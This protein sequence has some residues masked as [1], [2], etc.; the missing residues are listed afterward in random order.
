[1]SRAIF[2]R[3]VFLG[4][5]IAVWFYMDA[6]PTLDLN[7]IACARVH[8]KGSDPLPA[9]APLAAT[10]RFPETLTDGLCDPLQG[11]ILPAAPSAHTVDFEFP[12]V[13]L[14]E[15][16]VI[17]GAPTQRK[18]SLTVWLSHQ[19]GQFRAIHHEDTWGVYSD[20]AGPL[21][22]G[23]KLGPARSIHLVLGGAVPTELRDVA[24]Y[25]RA[26]RPFALFYSLSLNVFFPWLLGAAF[27]LSIL[28]WGALALILARAME[29]G[30]ISMT[31][32]RQWLIGA[33]VYTFLCLGWMWGGHTL[34]PTSAWLVVTVVVGTFELWRRW[35]QPK[36]ES[37]SD[38]D[39]NA[40]NDWWILAWTWRL[41]VWLLVVNMVDSY[42]ITHTR[43]GPVDHLLP[44]LGARFL[45]DGV[46][47]PA[48][49]AH[50]PWLLHLWF[51]PFVN[52]LRPWDYWAYL[53]FLANLNSLAL[54]IVP[55]WLRRWG[56][57]QRASLRRAVGCLTLM[58]LIVSFH[59]IGQRPFTALWALLAIWWWT[60]SYRFRDL[61]GGL[62]LT[63]AI[64]THPSA[65]FVL[66][67]VVF[68]NWWRAG[69]WRGGFISLKML[70]IPV[71]AYGLWNC[72]VASWFPMLR[73][74]LQYYPIMTDFSSFD[75]DLSTWQIVA[76]LPPAHWRQLAWNRLGHF[77]QYFIPH[78]LNIPILGAV[79]SVSLPHV[80]GWIFAAALA[81][82]YT[83][84]KDGAFIWLAVVAPLLIHHLYIGQ[85]PAQ[86]HVS[87]VPFFA[88][89]LLL[90]HV[91]VSIPTAN[92]YSWHGWW[93]I[94]AQIEWAAHTAF[95]CYMA[96]FHDYQRLLP[97]NDYFAFFGH[98]PFCDTFIALLPLVVWAWLWLDCFGC[99]KPL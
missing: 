75:Q 62:A 39:S 34:L 59:F 38:S 93:F 87:A 18:T 58:P 52:G 4:L 19:E 7:I 99:G 84:A 9:H 73:N 23:K 41:S 12:F 98:D 45:A 85:A 89:G 77:P 63:F 61:W 13:V 90:L 91:A 94:F 10:Q 96:I 33:L 86:F 67:G 28:G 30:S 55:L 69:I 71:S 35:R 65:L 66:P 46:M 8:A 70:I 1:M 22:V 79:R 37:E 57:I 53:G 80:L 24:C 14:L 81:V 48:E 78:E 56:I 26:S 32:E 72:A 20:R 11:F 88:L 51:A 64:G 60:S 44:Y 95:L 25:I 15:R 47:P 21:L 83:W 82:R 31:W 29:G 92:W 3:A 27:S 40:N 49:L 74:P 36:A 42:L 68:Y 2:L 97:P 16:L 17:L 76:N 43:V 6:A 54:F 5:T 50:R